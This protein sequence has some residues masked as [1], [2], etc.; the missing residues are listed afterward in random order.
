MEI[1]AYVWEEIRWLPSCRK[2]NEV[3]WG[4][5]HLLTMTLDDLAMEVLNTRLR[6]FRSEGSEK[7]CLSM[8]NDCVF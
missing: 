2:W 7:L 6:E 8:G 3:D 4:H 5:S 1:K